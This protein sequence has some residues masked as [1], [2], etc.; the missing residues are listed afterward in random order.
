MS[1]TEYSITIKEL[2][3]RPNIRDDFNDSDSWMNKM[4]DE[5][6]DQWD[7]EAYAICKEEGTPQKYPDM[8]AAHLTKHIDRG[9]LYKLF[10]MGDKPKQ[11]R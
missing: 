7:K 5:E 1:K 4:S 10:Q 3:E 6:I 8:N 11:R 9:I 2:I